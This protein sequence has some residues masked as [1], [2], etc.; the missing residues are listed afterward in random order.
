MFDLTKIPSLAEAEWLNSPQDWSVDAD[1]RLTAR[2]RDKTDFWRITHYGFIR[3]D[4]HALLAPHQGGFSATLSFAGGY[5]ALYDQC[6]LMVRSGPEAWVKFGVEFTDG[7]PH[8]S[9]VV[10]HTTSDWSARPLPAA[11]A[12][13]VTIRATRIGDALLLDSRS[14]PDEAWRMERLAYWPADPATVFVGPYL[15]S[16][17]RAGFEASFTGFTLVPPQVRSLHT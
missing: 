13:P 11:L 12:A 1:R 5:E 14:E 6:G 4:G 15:C 9:S 17:E 3:D 8:L 16:P 10:T 2:S 7:V